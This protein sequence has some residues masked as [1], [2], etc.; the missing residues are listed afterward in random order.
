L[1]AWKALGGELA[2][3]DYLVRLAEAYGKGGRTHEGL[4]VL[5]EAQA[6]VRKNAERRFEAELF[7]VKG[8]LLL[9]QAR[10]RASGQI[11]PAETSMMVEIEGEGGTQVLPLQAAAELCLR[12]AIHVARQQQAK[13]LELRA[14]MSL[15]R[16]LQAQGKRAEAYQLLAESYAWFTEGF[17]TPELQAAKALLATFAHAKPQASGS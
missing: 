6:L 13:C 8:E 16:L 15:S 3:P 11:A 4:R 10:E 5:G 12:Q 1:T 17:E 2:L 14:V 9:Q 7:R